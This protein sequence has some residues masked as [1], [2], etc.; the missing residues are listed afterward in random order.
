MTRRPRRAVRARAAQAGA[1]PPLSHP[2]YTCLA[3]IADAQTPAS[4]ASGRLIDPIMLSGGLLRRVSSPTHPAW[5][6]W[7]RTVHPP[8]A[9]H[10]FFYCA[11]YANRRGAGW[12]RCT[13]VRVS[14]CW[15]LQNRK[16]R[17]HQPPGGHTPWRGYAANAPVSAALRICAL[18]VR[19]RGRTHDDGASSNRGRLWRLE[20]R[21]ARNG[22]RMTAHRSR[23]LPVLSRQTER[24]VHPGLWSPAYRPFRSATLYP[25][26]S[27][28]ILSP[29][30]IFGSSF[31]DEIVFIAESQCKC[32]PL[33]GFCFSDQS[34]HRGPPLCA[35]RWQVRAASPSRRG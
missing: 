24:I 19:K 15:W 21:E 14:I 6:A 28:F 27:R 8:E 25:S 13:A 2:T 20:R 30:C 16:R 33:P 10:L 4:G 34:C 23:Q 17:P 12:R 29:V 1:Y 9:V 18:H 11:E 22:T 32:T 5:G 26:N 35:A 7:P 31:N 3:R